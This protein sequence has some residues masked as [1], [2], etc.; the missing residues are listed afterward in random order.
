MKYVKIPL[1]SGGGNTVS[2]ETDCI[3]GTNTPSLTNITI[4]S[5]TNEECTEISHRI[6]NTLTQDGFTT[7]CSVDSVDYEG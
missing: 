4:L 2:F 7:Y 5:P 6:G 1:A 3:N